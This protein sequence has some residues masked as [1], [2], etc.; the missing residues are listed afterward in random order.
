[1]DKSAFCAHTG[2]FDEK[3]FTGVVLAGKEM[4]WLLKQVAVVEG[5]ILLG[6]LNLR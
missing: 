5:L 6:G 3:L 4:Y 2:G 1:M